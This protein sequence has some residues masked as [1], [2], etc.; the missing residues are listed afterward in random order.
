MKKAVE[1]VN[2]L[3]SKGKTNVTSGKMTLGSSRDYNSTLKNIV[4][5]SAYTQGNIVS[6]QFDLNS[7]DPL[8]YDA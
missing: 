8:L 3:Y 6:S 7:N 2:I 4:V 1:S 5:G